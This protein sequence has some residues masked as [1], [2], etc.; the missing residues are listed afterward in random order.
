MLLS[1]FPISEPLFVQKSFWGKGHNER[2][3]GK[4]GGLP[5]LRAQNKKERNKMKQKVY[6]VQFGIL[7][8]K[9]L[10]S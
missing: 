4:L 8:L 5:G 3:N 9:M 2:Y 10:M 7:G 6:V 1:D